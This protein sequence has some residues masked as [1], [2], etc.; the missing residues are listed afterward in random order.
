MSVV[1]FSVFVYQ[2]PLFLFCLCSHCVAAGHSGRFSGG[3]DINVFEKVHK[4]GRITFILSLCS[5]LLCPLN[6][7]LKIGIWMVTDN[8]SLLPDVSVD[9][10]MNIMEGKR[11][12][13]A[14]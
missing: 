13:G 4:T 11:T 8:V 9:L 1:L 12:V 7:F 5:S 3:F 10:V 2:S 14:N 6:L